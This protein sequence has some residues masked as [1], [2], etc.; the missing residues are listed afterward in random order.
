MK[1]K[2]FKIVTRH[3][4]TSSN[5]YIYKGVEWV[6]VS[7]PRDHK[8]GVRTYIN[9]HIYVVD[10]VNTPINGGDWMYIV[11]DIG[12][13]YIEECPKFLNIIYVQKRKIIASTDPSMGLPLLP[14]SFV[15]DFI[16]SEC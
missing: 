3:T 16:A 11:S 8:E 13:T 10:D 4:K 9:Q 7:K 5:L 12:D 2:T 14:K 1:T 15:D 6:Y